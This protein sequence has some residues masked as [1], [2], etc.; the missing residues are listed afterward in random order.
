VLNSCKVDGIVY[1]RFLSEELHNLHCSLNTV[2]IRYIQG[3]CSARVM[4][5]VRNEGHV[6]NLGQK[7]TNSEAD[8]EDYTLSTVTAT[9]WSRTRRPKHCDHFMIYCVPTCFY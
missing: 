3:G 8:M 1:R 2:M 5:V 6:E 9:G 7:S 4:H